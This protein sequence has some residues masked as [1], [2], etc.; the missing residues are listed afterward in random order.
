MAG[1]AARGRAGRAVHYRT[2]AG[3]AFVAPLW[4]LV[5]HAANH[6]T[7]HRGQVTLMLRTLGAR[8]VAT[9]LL[10]WD[11]AQDAGAAAPE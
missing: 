11:R 1:G 3:A 8:L 4:K 9:D 2:L 7:Y 5:Q 6:S 10:I